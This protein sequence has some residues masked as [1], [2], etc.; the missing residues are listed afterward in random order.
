M[1]HKPFGN[2]IPYTFSQVQIS[3]HTGKNLILI[4]EVSDLGK[5]FVN[6]YESNALASDSDDEKRIYKV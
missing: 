6:E 2:S 3:L 5:R 1:C 4:S